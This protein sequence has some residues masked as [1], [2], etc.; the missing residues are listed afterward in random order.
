LANG[1]LKYGIKSYNDII[2]KTDNLGNIDEDKSVLINMINELFIKLAFGRPIGAS[3][4]VRQDDKIY[5]LLANALYE[6]YNL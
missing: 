1:G 6:D 2:I 3:L 4:W 5:A